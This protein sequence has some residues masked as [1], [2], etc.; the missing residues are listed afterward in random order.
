M[1]DRE[2]ELER[3][4]FIKLLNRA[5]A[6]AGVA[7]LLGPVISFF[8]PAKLEEVPSQPISVGA[9]DSIPPGEAKTVRFGRY[10]AIVINHQQAGLV[11]YSAVCTHFACLVKWNPDS[12]RLECPCHD[13]YFNPIDG[14]V[15][16]GPPPS[17]LTPIAVFSQ[18]GNL[19]IGGEA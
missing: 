12:G 5:L 3:R 19:M 1:T 13:G 17:P 8:W 11:A 10:P 4:G 18:D 16:S 2:P 6:L 14:S 15:I 9:T 7:A